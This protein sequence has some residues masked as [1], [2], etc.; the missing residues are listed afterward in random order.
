ML[1]VVV[2]VVVVK[3]SLG[4]PR[5]AQDGLELKWGHKK[6]H[7]PFVFFVIKQHQNG[8]TTTINSTNN[9]ICCLW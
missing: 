3:D 2:V 1:V 7:G 9:Q 5:I 4:Y 6:K 8:M